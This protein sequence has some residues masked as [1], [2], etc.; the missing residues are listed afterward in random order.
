MKLEVIDYCEE[1]LIENFINSKNEPY[2]SYLK[3]IKNEIILAHSNYK[4]C[5]ENDDLETMNSLSLSENQIKAL[6]NCYRSECET[7][8]NLFHKMK[9]N[10]SNYHKHHC[11]YCGI[12]PPKTKDHYIPKSEFPEFSALPINILYTCSTCNS[13]KGTDW[14]ENGRRIFLNKYFDDDNLE[15]FLKCTVNIVNDTLAFKYYLDEEVLQKTPKGEIIRSHYEYF[16]LINIFEEEINVV[17]ELELSVRNYF[18]GDISSLKNSIKG[19]YKD[20]ESSDGKNSYKTVA[21]KSI[22]NSD[23]I[24]RWIY[25]NMR[26]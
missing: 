26:K 20:I 6:E 17:S 3:S 10:L 25:E 1:E 14:C 18:D 23:E 12:F 2:K 22:S 4:K 11:A 24:I 15:E 19:F 13:T 16:D 9:K 7:N 21:Y 8:K 5:G